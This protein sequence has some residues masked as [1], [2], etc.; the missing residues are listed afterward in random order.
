[1]PP[2]KPSRLQLLLA[3]VMVIACTS[4]ANAIEAFPDSGSRSSVVGQVVAP[5]VGDIAT[6]SFTAK[7]ATAA[8]KTNL[9]SGSTAAAD[10]ASGSVLPGGNGFGQVSY[11]KD[12]SASATA[13]DSTTAP[14]ETQAEY[15]A[16]IRRAEKEATAKNPY[17]RMQNLVSF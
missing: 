13:S 4:A 6:A 3:V 2:S 16:R 12:A 5:Q 7:T 11:N 15:R 10:A 17:L 8:A 14:I 9:R 1:M